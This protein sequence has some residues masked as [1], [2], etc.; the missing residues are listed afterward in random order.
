MDEEPFVRLGLGRCA[1]GEEAVHFKDAV[2]VNRIQV[3]AS[4]AISIVT[5]FHAT[6]TTG[7][8]SGS[9][10]R[11]GAETG[12]ETAGACAAAWTEAGWGRRTIGRMS[13]KITARTTMAPNTVQTV[14][15]VRNNAFRASFSREGR[16]ASGADLT[17]RRSAG[18]GAGPGFGAG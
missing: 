16:S 6:S 10:F 1:R 18:S 4:N 13:R 17:R 14:A 11:G 15:R 8:G 12:S 3:S 2:R 5:P 9:A 7:G